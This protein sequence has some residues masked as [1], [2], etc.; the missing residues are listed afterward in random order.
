M[1][2]E[3]KEVCLMIALVWWVKEWTPPFLFYFFVCF[4]FGSSKPPAQLIHI[5]TNID[6]NI[7]NEL[8]VII[9]HSPLNILAHLNYLCSA[10]I[11]IPNDISLGT[12]HNTSN[13]MINHHT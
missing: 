5:Y 3:V 4:V 13:I 8:K 9:S 10:T 2:R 12:N 11:K 1:C 7:A 6:F